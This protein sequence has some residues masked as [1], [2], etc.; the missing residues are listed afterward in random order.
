MDA[1]TKMWVSLVGI[2]LMA[3][4]AVII[5]IA[6]YK[7]KGILRGILSFVAFGMLVLG[8]ILGFISIT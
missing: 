2:G 3:L 4:A 6:R 8:G 7:T 5:S 1:M